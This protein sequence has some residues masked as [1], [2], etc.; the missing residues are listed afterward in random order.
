[1]L[2]EHDGKRPSIDKSCWVAPNAVVVGDVSIGPETSIGYGAVLTAE[3][4]PIQI[5]RNCIIMENAVLRGTRRFPLTIGDHVLIGP[6][7]SI[8][9]CTI[10]D[11]VFLATHCSIFN[12]SHIGRACEI[13]ING[14]VYVNTRLDSGETVPTG[15]V[16][17]GNPAK[18]FP[19]ENH[20]DI[21]AVQEPLNF[22][23]TVFGL[24]RPP[25]GESIMREMTERYTKLLSRHRDDKILDEEDS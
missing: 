25:P 13:R 5:G 16:A 14:V 3:S 10:E 2:I 4:G 6:Q 9:G 23:K 24:D 15:W 20:D 11:E 12:G 17:V 7:S 18:I 21:W 22:P 1:M 8:T 19:A